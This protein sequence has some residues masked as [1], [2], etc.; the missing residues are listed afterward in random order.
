MKK[1]VLT[2][3][4]LLVAIISACSSVPSKVAK[5]YTNP[6]LDGAPGWVLDPASTPGLSGVGSAQP[7]LGGIQFQRTEAMAAGRDELARMISLK[8]KNSM[9]NFARQTGVGDSQ[10]FDKVAKDT[11]KQLAHET[12]NGSRQKDLWVAQDGTLWVLV[13]LDSKIVAEAAKHAVRSSYNND[14]ALFQ[15]KEST[16]AL[17]ELDADIDKEFNK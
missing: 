11:S 15:Q 6:S 7:S 12:L 3:F 4:C 14:N 13:T 5:G 16:S 2:G 8:V 17:K 1:L 9:E 10:T